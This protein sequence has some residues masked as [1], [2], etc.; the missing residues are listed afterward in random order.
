MIISIVVLALTPRASTDLKSVCPMKLAIVNE[1]QNDDRS[2]LSVL[3]WL[4]GRSE[5]PP[6][7]PPRSI[8]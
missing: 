2:V 7:P 1:A 6:S 5:F 8:V 4:Y 3:C